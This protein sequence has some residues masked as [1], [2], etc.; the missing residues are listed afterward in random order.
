MIKTI[1]FLIEIESNNN[2]GVGSIYFSFNPSN[3]KYKKK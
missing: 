2:I 1:I 3:N